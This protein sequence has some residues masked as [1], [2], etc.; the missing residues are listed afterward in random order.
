M[1]L[2]NADASPLADTDGNASALTRDGEMSLNVVPIL[3]NGKRRLFLDGL[4]VDKLQ[5]WERDEAMNMNTVPVPHS[6]KHYLPDDDEERI[7]FL[8]MT[9]DNG[10]GWRSLDRAFTYHIE[11]GL[12]KEEK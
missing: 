1:T 3:F 11:F 12:E 2:G 6:W 4:P 7:I 8:P 5:E 9:T 10:G